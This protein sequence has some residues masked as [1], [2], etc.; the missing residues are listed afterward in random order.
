M[1]NVQNVSFK[2]TKRIKTTRRQSDFI[3]KGVRMIWLK[4]KMRVTP[5]GWSQGGN[6]KDGE[7]EENA[8]HPGSDGERSETQN[9]LQFQEKNVG[10]W[11]TLAGVR[12]WLWGGNGKKERNWPAEGGG[13]REEGV[14]LQALGDIREVSRKTRLTSLRCAS[15]VWY[16][17]QMQHMQEMWQMIIHC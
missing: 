3:S 16:A 5:V 14:P 15:C 13:G 7:E 11:K 1:S 10:S 8:P 9:R 12:H 6:H 17:W 2:S 4:G